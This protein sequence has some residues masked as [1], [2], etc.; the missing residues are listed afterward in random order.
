MQE[1]QEQKRRSDQLQIPGW[2]IVR[3]RHIS[4]NALDRSLGRFST[5]TSQKVSLSSLIFNYT[6]P[7][8]YGSHN[9]LQIWNYFTL[10]FWDP[11]KICEFLSCLV[12]HQPLHEV[13]F[14]SERSPPGVWCCSLRKW[15][16]KVSLNFAQYVYWIMAHAFETCPLWVKCPNSF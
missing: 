12:Y 14:K 1:E 13:N 15:Y 9:Y 4:A 6:Q 10:I 3:C 2:E 8:L 7:G 11:Y 16:F 5:T